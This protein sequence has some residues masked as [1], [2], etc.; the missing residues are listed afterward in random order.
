MKMA[1]KRRW[2]EQHRLILTLETAVVLPAAALIVLGLLHVRGI[3]RDK[4]IQAAFERDFNQLLL[5]SEKQLNHK[6]Y[7]LMDDVAKEFPSGA[8]VCDSSLDAS[9]TSHPYVAHVFLYDPERG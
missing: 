8:N 6:A 1:L 3:E 4:G 7:E 5:I 2:K 9:L